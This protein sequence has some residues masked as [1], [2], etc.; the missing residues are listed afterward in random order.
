MKVRQN[1]GIRKGGRIKDHRQT[2]PEVWGRAK[3]LGR[4][5]T[6]DWLRTNAKFLSLSLACKFPE[7]SPSY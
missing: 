5:V 2:N 3:G 4:L 6:Y 1:R 7:K